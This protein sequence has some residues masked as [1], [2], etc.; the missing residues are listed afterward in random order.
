VDENIYREKVGAGKVMTIATIGFSI[1]AIGIFAI[2]IL[3]VTTDYIH[4]ADSPWVTVTVAAP[5]LFA[6]LMIASFRSIKIAITSKEI[7]VKYGF[8]RKHFL[9]QEI[10]SCEQIEK[11]GLI[12]YGG[13]GMRFGFDNSV[14]Y[15]TSYGSAVKVNSPGKKSFVF[16]TNQPDKICQIISTKKQ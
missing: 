4:Y 14:A 9:L 1:L 12:K 13:L 10:E 8:F 15:L 5:L 7:V 11:S 2:S 16:S 3:A 6:A